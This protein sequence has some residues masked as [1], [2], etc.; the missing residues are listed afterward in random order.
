MSTSILSRGVAL[1][2]AVAISLIAVFAMA[3]QA[4]ATTLYACVKK[5]GGS[6][7]LVSQRSKCAKS[8]RKVSWS[9]TGPAGKNGLNGANGATGKNGT[10]GTNGTAGAPGAPG[11]ALGYAKLSPAGTVE[12]GAK[13]VTSANVTKVGTAGYCFGGMAF[14]PAIAAANVA[15][16]GSDVDAFAQ[17]E[18]ASADPNFATD[19][20]CPAGSTAM[21]FTAEGATAKPEPFYVLFS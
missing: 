18:L 15:F 12:P 10:N 19:T 6:M 7:R 21:V 13:G 11:T 5:E 4:D 8:E 9:T 17:V 14:T 3:S 1:M 20:G 16:V 2:T